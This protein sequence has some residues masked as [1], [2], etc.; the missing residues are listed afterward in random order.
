[1]NHEAHISQLRALCERGAWAEVLGQAQAWQ[2]QEPGAA[3]AWFY[4][5]VAQ[6][7]LGQGTAAEASYRQALKL[8]PRDFKAWNN[9]AGLLFEQLQRPADAAKCLAQALE[10]DPQNKLGWA[11]LASLNGQLGR[12]TD[13]LTCAERALA[14]DPE[15]VAAHLHRA[16]AAQQLGRG[17]VVRAA[18]EAL[19]RLPVSRFRSGA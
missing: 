6:A 13:A 1:M 9:L 11:N 18:A 7:A 19:A 14:L 5:G 3:R 15:Y 4:Q 16:R 12:H 17:D 2:R 10:L 8:D